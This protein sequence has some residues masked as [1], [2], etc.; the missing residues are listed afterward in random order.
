MTRIKNS[1]FQRDVLEIAPEILGNF[2]VRKFD[3]GTII[4]LKIT[5]VEAY[6]GEEDLA[7]HARNGRTKRTEIMYHK[8]GYI[9]V[10]LI[11]GIYWMLN[12]VTGMENHPQAILIRGIEKFDGPGKLSKKLGIDKSFYGENVELSERIH[13][14]K[15]NEKIKISTGKRIGI[16]YA[17]ELWRNKLWRFF[18]T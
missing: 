18:L 8:G 4:K 13:I 10:Y 7:C 3:D 1:F 17:P 11:Y 12:I 9:Y 14:E 5:E 6:R 2:L 15:N 16:N